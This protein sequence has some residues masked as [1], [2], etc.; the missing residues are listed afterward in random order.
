M[1]T[2][3]VIEKRR[4]VRKYL[5]VPVEWEKVGNILR[6][7]QYAPSAGN[8]Q[9]WKFVV[10]T[11]KDT[12][13][14]IANAAMQ[15]SW[16]EEAPVIIVVY[17]EP[18]KTKRFYG[19]IGEKIYSVQNCAAA[20]ENMLLAAT[21]QDLG[22]CWISAFDE[23]MLCTII[24]SPKNVKPQAIVTIGY[25]DEAPITPTKYHLYDL[26]F[27]NAWGSRIVNPDLVLDNWSDVILKKIDEA[28]EA[29]QKEA[30]PLVRRLFEKGKEHAKKIHETIKKKAE[31]QKERKKKQQK[32]SEEEVLESTEEAEY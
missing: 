24:N 13:K 32:S 10:V 27:I 5:D 2:F 15:Q 9:D 23:S 19:E 31:E 17:S 14:K 18:Y 6:A 25:P 11:D 30:T 12:K 7:A 26:T 1:E 21:D 16:I 20:I 4:S 28:K 8:L 3:E 29:A 22:S